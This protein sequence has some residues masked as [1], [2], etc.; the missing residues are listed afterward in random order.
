MSRCYRDKTSEVVTEG[1]LIGTL[2]CWSSIFFM[3]LYTQYCNQSKY[4]ERS[5]KNL[6]P[7]PQQQGVVKRNYIIIS[8]VWCTARYMS[9]KIKI[10]YNKQ[11]ITESL[12]LR[13]ILNTRFVRSTVMCN[14]NSAA[15]QQMVS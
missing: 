3:F 5:E 1:N 4:H 7:I 11:T 8:Y 2:P 6:S 9:R 10:T 15:C 14:V 13:E 12:T